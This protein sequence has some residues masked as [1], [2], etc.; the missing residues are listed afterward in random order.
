MKKSTDTHFL[1][2]GS[3]KNGKLNGFVKMYGR[4]TVDP[5]GHCSNMVF[6]GLSFFGWYENGI[7][8][9]PCWRKLVGSNYIHGTVDK[10]GEFTGDDIAYIYQDLELALVGTFH[11]GIMVSVHKVCGHSKTVRK[12]GI[13]GWSVKCL[14]L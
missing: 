3:L 6:P 2:R 14:Y 12:K 10:D 11:R 1:I 8:T 4:Y 13:G 5:K 9:G 7:P